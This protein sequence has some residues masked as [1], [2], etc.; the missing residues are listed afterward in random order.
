QCEVECMFAWTSKRC[1][2][3][4]ASA[5]AHGAIEVLNKNLSVSDLAG[6]DGGGDGLDGLVDQVGCHRDFDLDLRQE[7]HRIFRSAIIFLV[8]ILPPVALDFGHGH[9]VHAD[10]GESSADLVELERLDDGHDDFHGVTPLSGPIPAGAG[11]WV[12]PTQP[13]SPGT[14]LR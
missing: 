5:D 11:Y 1:G 3:G 12:W 7:A 9:P 10:T 6:L 2:V 13:S 4:L 14:L 8:T